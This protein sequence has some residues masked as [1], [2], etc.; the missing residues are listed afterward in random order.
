M[1]KRD[2]H[3][4][5]KAKHG[6]YVEPSWCSERLFQ[7]ESFPGIVW[8]PACG[9]GRITTSA[10]QAGY[11]VLGSDLINRRKHNL[12][13][14]FFKHDFVSNICFTHIAPKTFSVVTN[15]PFDHVEDYVRRSFILGAQKVAVIMLVRRLNAAHWM[16]EMPL[17]KILLLTPRPSMPPGE[18]IAGGNE[19][20]GGTQDFCWAIFSGAHNGAAWI[21]WLSRDG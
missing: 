3:V 19:P 7:E 9:W 17:E 20:G 4:F 13:R 14:G 5:A 6:W 2:S 8:D 21:G 1:K 15:P 18:W 16:R 11:R 10:Q 12:G